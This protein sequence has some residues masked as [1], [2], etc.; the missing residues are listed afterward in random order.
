[1]K[2]FISLNVD[3]LKLDSIAGLCGESVIIAG[4]IVSKLGLTLLQSIFDKLSADSAVFDTLID[5]SHQSPL[6]PEIWEINKRCGKYFAEL[7][8]GLTC[9][10]KCSD[11]VKSAAAKLLMPV[12]K[13]VWSMMSEPIASQITLMQALSSRISTMET[14][15]D[16]L[17]ALQLS[18]VWQQFLTASLQFQ[19]VY[20]QRL[21]ENADA[22]HPPA[23]GM[24]T[25]IVR[26][27]N[28]FCTLT[29]QSLDM[30][31]S[32]EMEKMFHELNELRRKYVLR[33]P[34]NLGAGRRTTIAPVATQIYTGR[35][36][37]PLPKVCYG[38]EN[39]PAVELVFGKDFSLTY[40]NNVEVGTACLTLHGKGVY[41]GTKS[42]TF[43]IAAESER[44]EG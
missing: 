4:P 42:V 8:N 29:E 16:A 44:A 31:P 18:D 19:Q 13:P 7:K 27:Y 2:K 9:F 33:L 41:R 3:R 12:F 22:V 15:Q 30:I 23:S 6:T 26:D 28:S 14:L 43:N 1:M 25:T 34:G 36:I 40:K 24:K 21:Q 35:A 10:E 37:T 39:R 5:R 11:P 38:M 17:F 32:A 20:A